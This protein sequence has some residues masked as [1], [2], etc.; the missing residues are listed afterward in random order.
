MLFLGFF[1]VGRG[2][3]WMVLFLWYLIVGLCSFHE[4]GEEMRRIHVLG[5]FELLK[6]RKKKE[7]RRI[8][9]GVYIRESKAKKRREDA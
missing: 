5:I 1:L 8:F 2:W 4:G 3:V 7:G 9:G 6:M